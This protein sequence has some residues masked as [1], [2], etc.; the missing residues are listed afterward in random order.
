MMPLFTTTEAPPV[1]T[2][3]MILMA[4]PLDFCQALIAGLGPTYAA[5]SWLASSAVVSCVPLLKIWVFSVTFL[6]SV[7]VKMPLCTPTRAGACVMFARKP[8]RSVTA[9]DP[10]ELDGP[11]ELQPAASATVVTAAAA[12]ILRIYPLFCGRVDRNYRE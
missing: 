4:L 6:P 3:E 9:P 7:L 12:R 8:S 1:A 11:D 2:P 5:S 10:P